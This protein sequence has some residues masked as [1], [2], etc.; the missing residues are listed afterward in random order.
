VQCMRSSE[1]APAAAGWP[2]RLC[3]RTL[4]AIPY[5]KAWNDLYDMIHVS[6]EI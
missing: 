5:T 4:Q 6:Y 3:Y 2:A 1:P